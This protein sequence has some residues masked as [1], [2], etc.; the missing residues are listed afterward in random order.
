VKVSTDVKLKEWQALAKAS[1]E[2]VRALRYLIWVN[3]M[4]DDEDRS[5]IQACDDLAVALARVGLPQIS[6]AEFGVNIKKVLL[7]EMPED[8]K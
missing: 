1:I 5:F 7:K 4:E 6:Q 3:A 2:A 8:K